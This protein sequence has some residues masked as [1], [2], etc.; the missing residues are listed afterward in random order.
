[1]MDNIKDYNLDI[2]IDVLEKEGYILNSYVEDKEYIF[3][4]ENIQINVYDLNK[5]EGK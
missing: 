2:I 3:Q 1:M 4:K 5:E